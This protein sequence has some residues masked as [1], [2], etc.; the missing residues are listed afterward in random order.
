VRDSVGADPEARAACHRAAWSA[1]DHIGIRN[2]RSSFTREVYESLSAAPLYDP[3]LD[4]LVE[5][6]DGLWVAN[7]LCWFDPAA[8]VGHFEPVGAHPDYRGQRL[9]GVAMHEALRRLK[10]AGATTARVG[11][12]HF[13][14][15][16]IAAYLAAGF[17]KVDESW[18]WTRPSS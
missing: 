10:A 16:A 1:L 8:G 6:P 5:A 17:R 18:W 3:A 9:A 14:T 4:I 15:A 13:S 2:A 11:T 7:S 12:A